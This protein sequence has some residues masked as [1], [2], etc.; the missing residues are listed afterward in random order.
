MR[1]AA[2]YNSNGNRRV[3]IN[4][5]PIGGSLIE[6][7]TPAFDREQNPDKVWVKIRG[8]SCNFR[9]KALMLLAAQSG[10]TGY[11]VIGSEFVGEVQQTG[12][13]VK[14]FQPGDRVI[15]NNSWPFTWDGLP[16]GIPTNHAAK[17]YQAFRPAQLVKIPAQMSDA[18]AAVFSIGAQT[19][20]SMLR[21]LDIPAGAPVL[22]TAAKSN[23]SLFIFEALRQCGAEIWALS[24]SDQH[25][26]Q[27]Q[28]LGVKELVMFDPNRSLFET[29]GR[30]FDYIIDPFFDIY[31]PFVMEVMNPGAK[32]VTCG[33]HTQSEEIAIT[34]EMARAYL[35]LMAHAMFKNISLIGNCLGT[36]E[37]LSRALTDYEGGRFCPV[38]DSV[39]GPDQVIEFL[40][41]TYNVPDRFGKVALLY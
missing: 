7:D 16:G 37:D 34:S 28:R 18:D 10:K 2:I 22:V 33:F 39:F 20:Y 41:R 24:R 26:D 31:L 19:V 35:G 14:G 6:T 1:C 38:I 30:G 12:L 23:T 9:D 17:E 3:S 36:P 25:A 27:L 29:L 4:G 40:D 13:H 32:Y 11:Y 8:F 15:A 5:F 21:K